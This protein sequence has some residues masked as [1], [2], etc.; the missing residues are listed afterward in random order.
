[1]KTFLLLSVTLVTHAFTVNFYKSPNC[2][3]EFLNSYTGDLSNTSCRQ[4]VGEAGG[5]VVTKTGP[6]DDG[7]AVA[8][9]STDDCD[10]DHLLSQAD[11]GC[12]SVTDFE[13]DFRSF[14]VVGG[15]NQKGMKM[16]SAPDTQSPHPSDPVDDH[17][18]E[19]MDGEK[20]EARSDPGTLANARV[21]QHGEVSEYLGQ[22]YKWHQ[23]A[24]GA[25]RGINV[26]DWDDDKHVINNT[27][28]KDTHCLIRNN[29][30]NQDARRSDSKKLSLTNSHNLEERDFLY[31]AC[32]FVRSCALTVLAGTQYTVSAVVSAFVSKALQVSGIINLWELLNQPSSSIRVSQCSSSKSDAETI[33][34]ILKD[35]AESISDRAFQATMEYNGVTGVISVGAAPTGQ[36]G[37]GVTCGAIFD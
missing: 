25:W 7:A 16:R 19:R 29:S 17:L 1:M 34:S 37:D 18:Y 15:V 33:A 14:N 2:A 22:M 11:A 23:V 20:L 28:L 35:F 32:N 31:G 21:R 10:P 8:F 13:S 30:P 4:D 26:E 27:K 9:Y 6:L 5:A 36:R 12:I 24:E 3:G